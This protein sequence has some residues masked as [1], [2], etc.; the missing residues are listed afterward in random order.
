MA[1]TFDPWVG[2]KYQSDGIDGIRV[3]FLGESHYGETSDIYPEYTS[4][5]VRKYGQNERA[6]FFTKV[7]K[8][9]LGYGKE[10]WISDSDRAEAWEK[11]AFYNYIQS[12][13][14]KE[15]ERPTPEMWEQAPPYFFQTLDELKPQVVVVL[16]LELMRNI[17]PAPEGI[18]VCSS[19]H[20]SA[21]SFSYDAI[22]QIKN[23]I[24][25]AAGTL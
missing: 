24:S 11:V 10:E 8:L 18:I 17:P 5:I 21:S 6:A 1:R 16:G 22:A 25:Q 9:I 20:P 15:R 4:D 23:A 19:V 7:A 13:L 2:S 14:P 3:L 12:I